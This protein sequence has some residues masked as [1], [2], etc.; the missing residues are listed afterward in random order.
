MIYFE[1][2]NETAMEYGN[3]TQTYIHISQYRNRN[4]KIYGGINI[5]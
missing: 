2:K 1:E 3:Y 4:Y 5:S